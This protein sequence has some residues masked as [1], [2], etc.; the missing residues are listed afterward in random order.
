MDVDEMRQRIEY[1]LTW[2]LSLFTVADNVR[3]QYVYLIQVVVN[4]HYSIFKCPED[5][6]IPR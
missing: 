3:E 5:G 1:D 6:S 4:R 2:N